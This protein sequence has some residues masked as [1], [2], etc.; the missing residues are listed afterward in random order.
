MKPIREFLESIAAGEFKIPQCTTCGHR[1][2]P[3]SRSCPKCYSRTELKSIDPVGIL[4]EFANSNI[5]NKG[6]IF[7]VIDID[8]IKIV[9]GLKTENPHAGMK[10]KMS[11]C[12][13][14]KDGS[15]YYDFD[16]AQARH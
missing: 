1:A 16:S 9:G 8:G 14:N 5:R 7:G 6:G 2:W 13:L 12:G 15:P 11:A 10:L 3:P 4:V